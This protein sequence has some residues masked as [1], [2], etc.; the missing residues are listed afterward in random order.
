MAEGLFSALLQGRDDYEVTSA[1]LA[2]GVGHPASA[3]TLSVLKDDHIDLAYFRSQPLDEKL[4]RE[5]THLFV[6]TQSHAEMIDRYLPEV[7]EKTYLVT[8]FCSDDD[9]RGH[10]IN[11]PY[12]MS[13][14][15]YQKTR[16]D[17]KN[18]L[19]SVLAFIEQT[20]TKNE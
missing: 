12:G 16:A 1:G 13:R 15:A 2:A 19:P 17:L 10:D 7:S 11:D 6:M 4:A 3:H 18:A 8:E 9:L 5:A 14:D 20:F